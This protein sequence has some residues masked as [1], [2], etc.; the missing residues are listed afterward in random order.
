MGRPNAGPRGGVAEVDDFL[1]HYGVKGMKWGVRNP[2]R[3]PSFDRESNTYRHP[4][5]KTADD[6]IYPVNRQGKRVSDDAARAAILKVAAKS[7][8]TEVLSN[9]Q[10]QDLVTRMNLEQQ[11]SRLNP[12]TQSAGQQ[13]AV[14]ALRIAAPIA[15]SA[16]TPQLGKYA[17]VAKM[18]ADVL[19]KKR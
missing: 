5:V 14:A 1:A 12:Q 17:P 7:S 13:F 3:S 10:L 18:V 2:D 8:G 4:S 9:K 19:S 15:V 6:V 11:Y 16:F